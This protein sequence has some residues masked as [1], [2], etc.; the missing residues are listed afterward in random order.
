MAEKNT[1]WKVPLLFC[2]VIVAIIFTGSFFKGEKIKPP[3]I[4]PDLEKRAR[5]LAIDLDKPDGRQWKEAMIEAGGGFS[6]REIKDSRLEKVIAQAL[7]KGRLDAACAA[8]T[9]M[10]NGDIRERAL[11]SI[12]NE[13]LHDCENVP[14]GVFALH[15]S[16]SRN[17]MDKM[18]SLLEDKWNECKN[19]PEQ[20]QKRIK[21]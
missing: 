13:S 14:W 17:N 6:A 19:N 3:R 10:G 20:E 8:V 4:S 12:L 11:F 18:R 16:G 1:G 15:G 2:A 9:L 21:Q 5:E 7:E